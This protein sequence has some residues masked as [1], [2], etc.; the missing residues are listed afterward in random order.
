MGPMKSFD[1]VLF[2][3]TG[4]TGRL[5]AARLLAQ[6]DARELRIAIAGRDRER[7]DA[8]RETLPGLAGVL[9]ADANAPASIDAMVQMTRVVASTAGPFARYGDAVVAA[10]ARHGVD[11]VDITGETPWVRRMI[12]AHH[13]EAAAQGARIVPFCGFDAVPSDLG[14]WMM[15]DHIR[16][17]LGQPT[18]EVKA[19]FTAKGGLNGGT[20]ASALAIAEARDRAALADPVLLNPPGL[21]DP[22]ERRANPD[23]RGAVHDADLG[24]WTVPFLMAPINTR[25][26]RRSNALALQLDGAAYGA[27]FRYHEAMPARRRAG[28]LGAGASALAMALA[29]R[30]VDLGAVRRLVARV[31]PQPGTGPSEEVRASGFFKVQLFAR[32]ADGTR[33][34]GEVS[35]QGDPGNTATVKFLTESALA[36]ALERDALPGGPSR[37]GILTPATAFGAV[38][39]ARLR[40]AGMTWTVTPE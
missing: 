23:Q 36:L 17:A 11:Y 34:R 31:G 9:V 13:T 1:V 12:D 40:R 7:L 25:V 4:F 27:P 2:G 20:L 10:C 30:A 6:P 24:R 38:L 5:A 35:D 15:V 19:F 39:V 3:A 28:R 33:V 37:G 18:R 16:R 29:A 21:R 32:A 22:A 26:V 8:L 14:A